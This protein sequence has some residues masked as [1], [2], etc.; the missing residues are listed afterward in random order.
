L[1]EKQRN[2]KVAMKKQNRRKFFTKVHFTENT[3]FKA[4]YTKLPKDAKIGVEFND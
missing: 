4:N 3:E 1:Q 2:V